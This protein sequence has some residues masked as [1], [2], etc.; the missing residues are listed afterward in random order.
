MIWGVQ[1][2]IIL[3]SVADPE[4]LSRIGIF[5]HSGSR[6]PDPT[7][8][9]NYGNFT[10]NIVTKLSKYGLGTRDLDINLSRI[11]GAIK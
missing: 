1:R 11:Q 5:I 2:Y 6:I 9:K 4:C 7:Q 8:Q 3:T 10:Q